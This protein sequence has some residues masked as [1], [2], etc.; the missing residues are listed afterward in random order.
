MNCRAKMVNGWCGGRGT[1]ATPP[2]LKNRLWRGNDFRNVLVNGV[3]ARVGVAGK[4][5]RVTD[6]FPVHIDNVP[7]LNDLPVRNNNPFDFVPSQQNLKD[8]QPCRQILVVVN[9]SQ[10]TEDSVTLSGP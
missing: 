1:K 9:N 4:R 2:K 3:P 5:H 10:I 6:G 8:V 7:D